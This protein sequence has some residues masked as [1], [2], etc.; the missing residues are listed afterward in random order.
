MTVPNTGA[1]DTAFENGSSFQSVN[2]LVDQEAVRIE[3]DHLVT[4]TGDRI[5]FRANSRVALTFTENTPPLL[6]GEGSNP[7][8]L[9]KEG[10]VFEIVDGSLNYPYEI[11]VATVQGRSSGPTSQGDLHPPG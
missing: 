6:S 3:P 4:R 7:F 9:D 11:N 2:I 8:S 1:S 5:Q 10:L